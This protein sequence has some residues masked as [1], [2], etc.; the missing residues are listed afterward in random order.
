MKAKVAADPEL[1]HL[2]DQHRA[3]GAQMRRAFDPI[4]ASRLG[5]VQAPLRQRRKSSTSPPPNAPARCRHSPN[6]GDRGNAGDRDFCRNALPIIPILA[7]QAQGGRLYAAAAVNH[8]LDSQ[9]ASAPG[10][11]RSH[12]PHLSRSG[13]G[14]LPDIHGKCLER[15]RLQ[16]QRALAD[17]GTVPGARRAR[18]AIIGWRR[19]WT[20]TSRHWSG[21]PLPAI[22]SMPPTR[23]RNGT[24]TGA[25][26]SRKPGT[27]GLEARAGIEPACK[28]LQSSA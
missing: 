14:D 22:R 2:A 15:S 9:L 7:V 27:R 18:R 6:G 21:R 19:E 13:G 11:R 3:L 10:R 24:N 26:R 4:A 8:A 20:R 28:D 25:S 16:E 12:R 17:E 23:K 1:R 5:A